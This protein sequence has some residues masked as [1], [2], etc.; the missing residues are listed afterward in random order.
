[1]EI[2]TIFSKYNEIDGF[3]STCKG[4]W[5]SASGLSDHFPISNVR[6]KIL[7]AVTY[8][9]QHLEN[10]YVNHCTR[11]YDGL[12]EIPQ[13]LFRSHVRYLDNKI[14]QWSDMYSNYNSQGEYLINLHRPIRN[15]IEALDNA[16]YNAPN[17]NRDYERLSEKWKADAIKASNYSYPTK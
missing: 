9:N 6:D 3:I 10:E 16:T 12:E 8:R 15:E 14:S 2:Q 7:R 11:L 5:Y 17:F 1:M 13:V 4:F